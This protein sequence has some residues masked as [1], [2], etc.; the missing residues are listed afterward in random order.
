[1]PGSNPVLRVGDTSIIR[2]EPRIRAVQGALSTYDP[3][4]LILGIGPDDDDRDALVQAGR[5]MRAGL[6]VAVLGP[7]GDL[8]MAERWLRSGCSAYLAAGNPLDRV[9]SILRF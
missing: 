2:C 7:D 3:D 1:M 8:A 4:W 6:R 9:M 5:L